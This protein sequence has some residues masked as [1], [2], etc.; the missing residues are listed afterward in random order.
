MR[1]ERA[2]NIIR[3]IT[4]RADARVREGARW[5]TLTVGASLPPDAELRTGPRASAALELSSGAT[6][7]VGEEAALRVESAEVPR[8]HHLN[9]VLSARDQSR[10]LWTLSR[11][12][13]VVNQRGIVRLDPVVIRQL[14]D[15]SA[16]PR[17]DGNEDA[18]SLSDPPKP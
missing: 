2:A 10:G 13:V 5:R 6:L 15:E 1:E 7:H 9:L 17:S 16:A 4:E 18:P 14:S 3:H 11:T 8:V 12:R